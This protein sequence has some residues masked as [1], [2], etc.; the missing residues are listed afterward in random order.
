MI[1]RIRLTNNEEALRVLRLQ[2]DSYLVEAKRIEYDDIPPLKDTIASLM[3]SKERFY[4]YFPEGT[5][6]EL[7]GAIAY[8]RE[9]QTV[10]ICRLMVRS[11]RF[12]QGIGSALLR[13]IE[14]QEQECTSFFVTAAAR[15][16][17]AIRLYTKHGYVEESRR[18]VAPGLV[19]LRLVKTVPR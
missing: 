5:D 10:M 13:F 12:R 14:Q 18:E 15:N 7:S 3:E 8:E 9:G 6:G 1:E 4:G 16:E 19:L 2:M 11:D 17:P